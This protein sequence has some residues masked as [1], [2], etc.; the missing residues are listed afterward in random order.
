VA[1][2]SDIIIEAIYKITQRMHLVEV[3]DRQE[4]ITMIGESRWNSQI[5]NVTL[6]AIGI[7][8]PEICMCFFSTFIEVNGKPNPLGPMVMMGTSSFN[9]LLVTG[10]AILYGSSV[11]RLY[12]V[13][14]FLVTGIFATIGFIWLFIILLISSPGKIELWEAIVTL[15]M[16]PI[17]VL[18][19]WLSQKFC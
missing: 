10:I 3:K 14:A 1:V 13:A 4:V 6:L 5:A 8:F 15:L 7:S 16:Y 2:L 11:K 9:I 18:S 17:L 12:D 19:I